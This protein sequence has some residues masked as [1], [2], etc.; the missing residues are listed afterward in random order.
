MAEP[1]P[2]ELDRRARR[3]RPS[4]W[5][6]RR[7]APAAQTLVLPGDVQAFY[8]APIHARVSGYLKRWYDDIGAQVK[9]GQVLADIDTPELD[10]QLA[11]AKAD[12]ATAVANQKLAADHR[13]RA[14]P[15]CWPRTRSRSRRPTRRPATSPPRPRWSTPRRPTSTGW[16]RW[17]A[18]SASPRR[19]TAWS[20]PAPPTSAR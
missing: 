9:A 2:E 7:P 16:R 19:S 10:Q 13:R 15:A 6:A 11:Q 14:G 17:K 20:P 4:A 12:L 18:S 1:E 3:S 8:N 5:S